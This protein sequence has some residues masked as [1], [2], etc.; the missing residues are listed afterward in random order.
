MP[1]AKAES[2]DVANGAAA[3]RGPLPVALHPF[4]RCHGFLCEARPAVTTP[5]A[6]SNHDCGYSTPLGADRYLW[7]FCDTELFKRADAAAIPVRVSPF[8][9]SNA[10]ISR[11]G[12]SVSHVTTIGERPW[13]FIN[14]STSGR[15]DPDW[16]NSYMAAWPQSATTLVG[17]S[18]LDPNKQSIAVVMFQQFCVRPGSTDPAKPPFEGRSTGIA[19]YQ[20]QGGAWESADPSAPLGGI[21]LRATV[22]TYDLFHNNPNTYG[23]QFGL[24]QRDGFLYTYRCDQLH[25]CELARVSLTGKWNGVDKARVASAANWHALTDD[26]WTPFNGDTKAPNGPTQYLWSS[27]SVPVSDPAI[28]FNTALG[29]YV[30]TYMSKGYSELAAVRTAVRPSGPWSEPVALTLP[31]NCLAA[32]DPSFPVNGC[33]QVIPHPELDHDDQ[34]LFTYY[35]VNDLWVDVGGRGQTVGRLHLASVPYAL[36][37]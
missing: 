12:D 28:V 23:F 34:M 21:G 32:V 26:G 30:M 9:T 10:G 36:L 6:E 27:G 3:E 31:S 24:T 2:S 15:C 4:D 7:I 17:E 20:Y 5:L 13:Q 37:P 35:D 33:Y 11:A 25:P 19:Y 8:V 16:P 22:L 18:N 29:K 1:S 14:A